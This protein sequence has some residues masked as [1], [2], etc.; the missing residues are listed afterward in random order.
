MKN[1]YTAYAKNVGGSL[2]YFVKS[3]QTFPEYE[4]VPPILENYGM[5]TNFDQACK[6]ARIDDKE[7]QLQLLNELQTDIAS[8]TMLPLYPAASEVYNLRKRNT[9]FPSILKLLRLG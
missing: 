1:F 4:N 8:S 7:I 9:T 6:I 3:F 2:F 5:H